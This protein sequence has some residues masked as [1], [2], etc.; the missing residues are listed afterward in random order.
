[1]AF[2][3]PALPYDH[4]ALAPHLSAETLAYH[5]G[6]HHKAHVDRLNALLE[7]SDAADDSLEALLGS[8]SGELFHHAAEA[9]NHTFYWHCLSPH[10]GGAPRGAL[11]VA[12]EARFGDLVAFKTAFTAQAMAHLGAGW[13]WLIQTPDGGVDIATTQD[14]DTPIAHGQIPLLGVDLW[15]HA[16]YI[17]YRHARDKY[18]E[19][20]WPLINWDFVALNLS[21]D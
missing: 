11:A 5:Y 15:E 16:H 21:A 14:A 2:E 10:G 20:I 13:I 18:L 12:L 4:N 7:E 3:L 6:Q 8:A 9:W 1:M 19:H 17:D